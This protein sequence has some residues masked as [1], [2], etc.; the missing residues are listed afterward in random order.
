[1]QRLLFSADLAQSD[2]DE[3]A[4]LDGDYADVVL[5]YAYRPI[6]DDR[7]NI[8][9]RYRYLYDMFGQRVDGVD[10]TGPRQ[11]SHVISIDASYDISRTWTIGGKLGYRISETSASES[12]VFVQNDAWLAIA[13]A[14][15]HLVHDWDILIEARELGTVQ[16]QGRDFGL[17]AAV[18]KQLGTHLEVGV[19]YNF[20]Q[21]SDDLTDLTDDSQGAFINLVAKF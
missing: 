9:A 13:N 17:L 11:R 3:S 10:E 18:Y 16:A 8:L 7:L 5:G 1:M 21:I 6:A 12:T 19:G 2:T 20:G 4:I 15:M 14:R